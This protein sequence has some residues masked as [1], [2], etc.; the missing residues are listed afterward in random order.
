MAFYM[1][2]ILH[3]K[4]KKE[5]LLSALG[6]HYDIFTLLDYVSMTLQEIYDFQNEFNR[7][8]RK[9]RDHQI[10]IDKNFR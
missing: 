10:A 3:Q 7:L 5:N 9:Y 8:R 2:E 4:L 6:A 1:A